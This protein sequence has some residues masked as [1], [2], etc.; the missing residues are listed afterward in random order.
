MSTLFDTVLL[1]DAAGDFTMRQLLAICRQ[2]AQAQAGD[3]ETQDRLTEQYAM[4]YIRGLN[5]RKGRDN[6]TA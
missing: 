1:S 5:T 2:Q 3:K 6:E 4:A